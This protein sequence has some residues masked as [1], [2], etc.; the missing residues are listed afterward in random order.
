MAALGCV[1]DAAH[2]RSVLLLGL[3]ILKVRGQLTAPGVQRFR[4]AM[5]PR[6]DEELVARRADGVVVGGTRFDV[7]S[8]R[9]YCEPYYA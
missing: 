2:D 8:A 6:E 1:Q 9:S 4:V 3:L 7:L 5:V